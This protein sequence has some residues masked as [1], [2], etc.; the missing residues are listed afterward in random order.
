MMPTCDGCGVDLR[1]EASYREADRRQCRY[2]LACD[3]VYHNWLTTLQQE[4]N[5]LNALLDAFIASSRV[6]VPLRLVPQ[7]LPKRSVARLGEMVLG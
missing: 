6:H 5:R 4:E 7:D 2:C 3:D 1:D